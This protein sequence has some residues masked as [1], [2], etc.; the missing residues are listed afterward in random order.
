MVTLIGATETYGHTI[1]IQRGS[2]R[3][4]AP[5]DFKVVQRG[6]NADGVGN[7]LSGLAATVPNT[8]TA[9]PPGASSPCS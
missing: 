9:W 3:T 2:H 6:L 7:L 4:A 8:T 1:A 5:V